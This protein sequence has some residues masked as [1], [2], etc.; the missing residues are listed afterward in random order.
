MASCPSPHAALSRWVD[1]FVGFLVTKHG[2]AAALRSDDGFEALH[3]Y[4]LERLV[5]VC[6]QLLS[7]AADAGE[8]SSD[9]PT[10]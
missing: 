5:P 8:I 4:F 7:A 1:L 10:N 3:A 2:L 9:V 6:A